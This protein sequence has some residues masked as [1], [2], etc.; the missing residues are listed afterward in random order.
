MSAIFLAFTI[1]SIYSFFRFVL[2][3]ANNNK[4]FLLAI[5]I[6]F[7]FLN[8]M[9][10]LVQG[11]YWLPGSMTYQLG[12]ILTIYLSINVLTSI[13]GSSN[14][15]KFKKISNYFLVFIIC[16]L[17]ETSMIA[18]DVLLGFILFYD[19]LIKRK[20]NIELLLY[21]L[22]ATAFSLIVILAPGNATR[23]LDFP[24]PDKHHLF[25]TISSSII[26][27]FQYIINWLSTPQIII[28]STLVFINAIIV[29]PHNTIEKKRKIFFSLFLIVGG[30]LVIVT[31]FFTGFW[32]TGYISP[33][34]TVNVS[35]WLFIIVWFSVLI[36]LV[37]LVNKYFNAI[38]KVNLAPINIIGICVLLFFEHSTENYS[39][40]TNDVLSGRAYLY[41]NECKNRDRIM[42]E[43][44]DSVCLIP[45]FSV[46]PSSIFNE[47]ISDDITSWWNHVYAN[48][49]EKHAVRVIPQK[50]AIKDSYIF[51]F[52]NEGNKALKNT[53]T[54][55]N[56]IAFSYP[57]SSVL[58]G[59]NSFSASFSKELKSLKVD[60]VSRISKIHISIALYSA[61]SIVNAAIVLCINEPNSSK[62]ILWKSKEIVSTNYK[63]NQWTKQEGD[64]SVEQNF[65]SEKNIINIYV[66]NTGKAKIYIDDLQIDVY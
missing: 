47:D 41:N 2:P 42:R 36:S 17:N 62:S 56:E 10:T 8:G 46:K 44:T 20:I 9:P 49:Y 58:N 29:I 31:S 23:N 45:T 48:Y 16:G 57:N 54:I 11:I 30:F 66:W 52:E 38:K 59:N 43:C 51:T 25:F 22:F 53:E 12:N 1:H 18:L 63:M 15:S 24:S 40:V 26:F 50:T 3:S 55:T 19:F 13:S 61:D 39:L 35:Y 28:S 21:V 37:P 14:S 33:P 32:S 34:R 64:I 4:I 60:D 27:A 7:C 5:I 65:L 6:S